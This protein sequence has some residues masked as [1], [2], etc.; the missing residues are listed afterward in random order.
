MI[1]EIRFDLISCLDTLQS[2]HHL[3]VFLYKYIKKD[4]KFIIFNCQ[5]FKIFKYH[6]APSLYYPL[7]SAVVLFLHAHLSDHSCS[8]LFIVKVLNPK[9]NLG[10][11][12]LTCQTA[13]S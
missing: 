9:E 13:F 6:V 2:E 7:V 4:G 10:L 1:S 3:N 11:S 8:N 5:F 12:S